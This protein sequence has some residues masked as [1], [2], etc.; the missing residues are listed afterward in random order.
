[1]PVWERPQGFTFTVTGALGDPIEPV[2]YDCDIILSS[3][4]N[5]VKSNYLNRIQVPLASNPH[6]DYDMILGWDILN[7]FKEIV[8][9]PG[10]DFKLTI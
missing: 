3:L 10:I 6:P 8:F 9:N 1:L 5:G 4:S 2:I 7:N